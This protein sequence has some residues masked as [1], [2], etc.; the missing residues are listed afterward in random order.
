MRRDI[1][2]ASI[3]P[4]ALFLLVGFL[5]AIH[6]IT[7]KL[8]DKSVYRG[9]WVTVKVPPGW[10][11]QI[12]GEEVMFVSPDMDYINQRPEAIF[13]VYAKQSPGALFLED[14]IIEVQESLMK[15]K[16]KILQQGDITLDGIHAKWILFQ[17]DEP[18][19]VMMTFYIVDDWNRMTR[20]QYITK[21]SLFSKYRPQ[22]EQFKDSLKIKKLF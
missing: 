17:Y 5:F 9:M 3:N 2:G 16:G 18:D 7:N 14:F 12:H 1:I 15:E 11:K 19:L 8:F 21:S 6:V 13:S 4:V 20:L 10:E 22:F